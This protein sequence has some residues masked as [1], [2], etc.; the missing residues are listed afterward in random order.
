MDQSVRDDA[1]TS[2]GIGHRELRRCV[3]HHHSKEKTQMNKL[4][5]TLI[6][7]T[8][9]A[10]STAAYAQGTVQK[11]ADKIKA[12][13]K[14]AQSTDKA[15]KFEAQEKQFQDL[16]KSDQGTAQQKANVE[17]SKQQPRTKAKYSEAQAQ[18]LSRSDQGTEDQKANVAASKAQSAKRQRMPDVKS[19]TPAEREQLRRELQKAS[20]P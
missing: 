9:A 6:A 10:A 1:G 14:A 7:G 12:D 5:A 16:S 3:R 2:R 19:L 4:L 18:D 8:F 11:E 13:V 15:K 20:T 17:A